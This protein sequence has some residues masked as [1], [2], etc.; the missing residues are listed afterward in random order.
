VRHAAI[1]IV[2]AFLAG[3]TVRPQPPASPPVS[4]CFLLLDTRS[5]NLK[6]EPA[7]LCTTR[8]PPASTFKIPHAIAA[9]DAGVIGGPDEVI[10]YDGTPYDYESW[11][12]DQTL[13]TAM[14]DSVVWF[15]QRIAQQMGMG[16]EEFYLRR[17]RYG[18]AD[19][20]SGLTMFWLGGSLRISPEEQ[21][22]FL[23]RL[24]YGELPVGEKAMRTVREIL[25]QPAGV[26]VNAT[27]AH[28][29]DAPWPANTVLS[30]KTGSTSYGRDR[31][32]RWIVGHVKRADRAW[33]FVSC[34]DGAA[35]LDANA[36]I[37]LAARSLRKND[38]L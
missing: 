7:D 12:R 3:G 21:L 16:R 18:N 4:S 34:V 26:I 20:S 38:V 9:L 36:A 32:V 6:R 1:P 11:R 8:L 22:T 28:P 27:G 5:G 33:I 15:F 17:L 14:R 2:L 24:Y 10:K 37:D 13:A 25:V 23:R 29:F 35:D 19:P 30:A 31:A